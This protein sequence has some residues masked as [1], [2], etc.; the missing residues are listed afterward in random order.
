M[1]TTTSSSAWPPHGR[2]TP[3]CPRRAPTLAVRLDADRVWIIDPL[4]GTREFGEVPRVD[5][6]V[7]VALWVEGRLV[8]GA[9]ALPGLGRTL[10]SSPATP[11]PAASG[12]PGSP[13]REP[14]PAAR[15]HHRGRRAPRCRAGAD[16]L[17]RR[18]GDEHPARSVRR[19]PARRRAV[20][21]G[22]GGARRGLRR[23][24]PPHVSR[25]RLARSS[26]TSPIPGCPTSSSAGRSWPR[27]CWARSPQSAGSTPER[28]T[29]ARPARQQ[30]PLPQGRGRGL[31]GG[32]RRAPGAGRGDGRLLGDGPP[33]EHPRRAG[34][35]LPLVRGV[36]RS[37]TGSGRADQDGRPH[38]VVVAG[39][40]RYGRRDRGVPPRRGPPAQRLPPAVAVDPERARTAPTCPSC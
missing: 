2:T 25:R 36:R 40:T 33:G 17:G 16:G 35:H 8:A 21:V 12:R 4:D 32:P 26:T 38:G 1:P 11:V 15:R 23:C 24:G 14:Y 39:A 22:L 31:H 9:V 3:C 10:V 19:V 29:G 37:A 30:V 18:Q 28:S 27:T 5:W 7:H 34:R 13:G 6:A 20:R